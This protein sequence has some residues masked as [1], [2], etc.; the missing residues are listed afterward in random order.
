M[1]LGLTEFQSRVRRRSLNSQRLRVKLFLLGPGLPT[2]PKTAAAAAVANSDDGFRP[3]VCAK[4][5]AT[6]ESGVGVPKISC[7]E[8]VEVVKKIPSGT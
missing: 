8:K 5:S 1:K 7:Q 3:L 4:H 2:R 6:T